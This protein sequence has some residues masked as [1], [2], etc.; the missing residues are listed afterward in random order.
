MKT[1]CLYFFAVHIA[2]MFLVDEAWVEMNC[3]K[4]LRFAVS[5]VFL[6]KHSVTR[7]ST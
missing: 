7:N 1:E 6:N 5:L 3:N 2:P 4:K